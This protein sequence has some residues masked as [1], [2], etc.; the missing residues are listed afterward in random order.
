MIW[1]FGVADTYNSQTIVLLGTPQG[2]ER[3]LPDVD[4]HFASATASSLATG[5]F[6][7]A[8]KKIDDPFDSASGNVARACLAGLIVQFDE[9]VCCACNCERAF[10]SSR[11][12]A[13][14]FVKR[15]SLVRVRTRTERCR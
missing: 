15:E 2:F 7:P 5:S 10:R 8:K 6:G 3:A 13:R 1:M 12:G 9:P 11:G 4:F 14:Y